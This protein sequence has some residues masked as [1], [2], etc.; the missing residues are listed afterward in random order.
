MYATAVQNGLGKDIWTL[1]PEQINEFFKVSSMAGNEV[2]EKRRVRANQ[3]R[4]AVLHWGA[5]LCIH[6]YVCEDELSV[7]L[8]APIRR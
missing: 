7:L 4:Q 3:T 5:F 6:R 1:T 2:G 8:L